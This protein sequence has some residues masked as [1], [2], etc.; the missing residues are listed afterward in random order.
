MGLGGL[1]KTHIIMS[2]SKLKKWKIKIVRITRRKNRK[3]C[4]VVRMH[5]K[6][7]VTYKKKVIKMWFQHYGSAAIVSSLKAFCNLHNLNE[8]DFIKI[9]K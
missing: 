6:W 5:D 9:K 4:C 7:Y 3:P 8:S 2:K 1:Y